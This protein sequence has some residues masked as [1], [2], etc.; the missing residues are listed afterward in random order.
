M[1]FPPYL[2]PGDKVGIVAPAGPIDYPHDIQ[3]GLNVLSDWGLKIVE[4]KSPALRHFQF[5]GTDQ[6]RLLDFQT[7]L[8]DPEIKAIWAVRGG[9][10][11]SRIIDRI[12]FTGFLKKTKWL[13][14]FSDITLLLTHLLK[15]G[16][17]SIHG[18]M[19]KHLGM[20]EGK[21]ATE[22][23]RRILWGESVQYTLKPHHYNRYGQAQGS[24]VGGNLCLFTHTLGSISEIDTAGKIL[25]LEDVGEPLYNLD[26]M[27][28][29]LRRAG[30]L[31]NLAGLMVGHFTELKGS[32]DSFGEDSDEIIY[33]HI[34]DFTYPVAFN[35][36]VGHVPDNRPLIL[37]KLARLTVEEWGSRLE[38]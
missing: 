21:E 4:G 25:F 20:E 18:P 35:L 36:Q 34:Q 17:A 6:E 3:E 15:M 1:F 32:A 27:L 28:W 24:M 5:A 38:F 7:M 13:I 22:A 37:G 12:D 2:T 9:Y 30:K 8:D 14:G 29:Q 16:I 26:R 19:V 33:H 10:G 31:S 23:V 11:S